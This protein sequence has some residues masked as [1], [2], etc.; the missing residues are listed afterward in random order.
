MINDQHE[1]EP[2]QLWLKERCIWAES[3]QKTLFYGLL[4]LI[5]AIA[6]LLGLSDKFTRGV[7]AFLAYTV[8]AALTGALAASKNRNVWSWG[9]LGSGWLGIIILL[10]LRPLCAACLNPIPKEARRSETCSRCGNN[11]GSR[12][13]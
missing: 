12:Y 10:F 5:A 11:R 4:L 1:I 9:L 2:F 13:A 7:C 6:L 8:A 3:H